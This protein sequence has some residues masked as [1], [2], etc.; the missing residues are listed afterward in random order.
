[1][2]ITRMFT[3]SSPYIHIASC[4]EEILQQIEGLKNEETFVAK[5]NG[6]HTGNQKKLYKEF[7]EQFHFPDYFSWNLNSFDEMINDLDWINKNSY[8]IIIYNSDRILGADFLMSK[9]FKHAFWEV[10]FESILEWNIGRNYDDFATAPTPFHVV[11][12]T[13]EVHKQKLAQRISG[14]TGLDVNIM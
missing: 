1:M 12:L 2:D 7:A 14:M 4:S 6:N 13:C 3:T 5:V 11:L 10:F 9:S 8:I